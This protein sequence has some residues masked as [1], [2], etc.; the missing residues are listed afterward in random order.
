M[1]CLRSQQQRGRVDRRH[2]TNDYAGTF[3]FTTFLFFK[4]NAIF[5]P[6]AFVR[7]SVFVNGPGTVFLDTTPLFLLLIVSLVSQSCLCQVLS[8]PSVRVSQSCH[9]QALLILSLSDSLNHVT[10][11]F[12]QSGHCQFLSILSLLGSLDPIIITVCLF[13]SCHCQGLSIL[14]LSGFLNPFTVRL[15][16]SCHC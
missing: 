16:Q 10:V 6:Y 15:T 4:S 7:F 9:C 5:R 3:P 8:V 12:S 14:S 2:V 13:Q 1:S 11:R